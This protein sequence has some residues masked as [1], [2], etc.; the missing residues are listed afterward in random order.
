MNN[1]TNEHEILRKAITVIKR[2]TGIRINIVENEVLKKENGYVDAVIQIQPH[3]IT[4]YVEVKKWAANKNIGAIINQIKN[5]GGPGKGLLVADY[6]NPNMA[7]KLKNADVQFLDTVGNAYIN[8]KQILYIY[9]KGNKPKRDANKTGRIK[10]DKA[11]QA[12]GLKVIFAFLKDR[13]LINAPYRDI[14]DYAQVALGTVGWVIRD[15]QAQGFILEGIKKKTREPKKKRELVKINLLVD[16][17][18]EAYPLKLKEKYKIGRFTTENTEWWKK[19]SIEKY[20][21]IWGGEIA[22]AKYT[23]YLN[24]KHGIVYIKKQNMDALLKTARLR[25]LEV[26]EISNTEIE[27]IEPFWKEEKEVIAN[28]KHN[29]LAHPIITYADL[30]ETG[31]ARNLETAKRIRDEYIN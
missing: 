27:L 28:P 20:H 24:P 10:T 6:I 22:A 9:I 15:L 21:G 7:D 31:E 13:D 29:F 25:K 3:D 14:A 19:I 16:K 5:I 23:H 8:Q 26:N 12:S 17:W 30:I 1:F 11:F 2:E 4:L 18:A